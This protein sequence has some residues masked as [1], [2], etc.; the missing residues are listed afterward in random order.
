M[1]QLVKNP[2]TMLETW[3]CSLGWEDPREKRKATHAMENCMDFIV[4]GLAKSRTQLSDFFTFTLTSARFFRAVLDASKM[5]REVQRFPLYPLPRLMCSFSPFLNIPQQN[6]TFFTLFIYMYFF[7]VE[8][9][10][11]CWARIFSSV[12]RRL[13]FV[14]LRG[15]LVSVA[16]LVV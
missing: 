13:R 6:P 14:V 1:A 15:L 9:G 2:P 4:H 8:L 12:R 7:L 11:R 5:E 16:S 3:V 10:P